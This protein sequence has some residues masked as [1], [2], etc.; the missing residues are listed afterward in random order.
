MTQ[1]HP[2]KIKWDK[3]GEG[4]HRFIVTLPAIYKQDNAYAK[5]RVKFNRTT[6]FPFRITAISE[7]LEP[8]VVDG[9][10]VLDPETGEP[11]VT[12]KAIYVDCGDT[13]STVANRFLTV[14][15]SGE[16]PEAVVDPALATQF[17]AFYFEKSEETTITL[18]AI[19]APTDMRPVSMIVKLTG[20]VSSIS[21][22]PLTGVEFS[23]PVTV[24]E[25]LEQVDF[26]LVSD[27][28]TATFKL[29]SKEYVGSYDLEYEVLGTCDKK[30][31]GTI[32]GIMR[33]A[34]TATDNWGNTRSGVLDL[35][36]D[37]FANAVIVDGTFL[38]HSPEQWATQGAVRVTQTVE[39]D[40][41]F[42]V[43]ANGSLVGSV[44]GPPKFCFCE[45]CC[46]EDGELYI[47]TSEAE[48]DKCSEGNA[49]D[50]L[51]QQSTETLGFT[52]AAYLPP[53]GETSF[54]YSVTVEMLEVETGITVRRD[55]YVVYDPV[56]PNVSLVSRLPSGQT[57]P[58]L[59]V[60]E[61]D[62]PLQRRNNFENGKTAD[63]VTLEI[64]RV[65]TESDPRVNILTSAALQFDDSGRISDERFSLLEVPGVDESG[66]DIVRNFILFLD[67]E[68]PPGENGEYELVVNVNNRAGAN[69][70][71]TL[72]VFTIDEQAP[73]PPEFL[74]D[75]TE[76][77]LKESDDKTYR[78]N[79]PALNLLFTAP[80]NG[81][82]RVT[83]ID[84]STGK[85]T[86][87]NSCDGNIEKTENGHWRVTL[88]PEDTS[89]EDGLRVVMA[90]II[91]DVVESENGSRSVLTGAAVG[92]FDVRVTSPPS[93]FTPKGDT[94]YVTT[95]YFPAFGAEYVGIVDVEGEQILIGE[96][97]ATTSYKQ[98][99]T[100]Q[101]F[102]S[103]IILRPESEED[104]RYVYHLYSGQVT[105]V[106][107]SFG[108]R[109][110]HRAFN[111]T[112]PSGSIRVAVVDPWGNIGEASQPW[113]EN[114]EELYDS[115]ADIWLIPKGG[116]HPAEGS[117]PALSDTEK[118]VWCDNPEEADWRENNV[119]VGGAPADL[120][121]YYDWKIVSGTTVVGT[122]Q[123]ATQKT[124]VMGPVIWPE[125]GNELDNMS[126][127]TAPA[128]LA[129]GESKPAG[130]WYENGPEGAAWP[131]RLNE[132]H[133]EK[134]FESLFFAT[135]PAPA[136]DAPEEPLFLWETRVMIVNQ[137]M[138]K[139][140]KILTLNCDGVRKRSVFL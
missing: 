60:L 113:R 38:F 83:H 35:G 46:T 92:A 4:R 30:R 17:P 138:S 104:A 39:T 5:F 82:A 109:F 62:V 117:G 3:R 11:A 114:T 139:A 79:K 133:F 77:P 106:A 66:A 131:A 110:L 2:A 48:P 87:Y 50:C 73:T 101:N 136:R 12:R 28:I 126:S 95:V 98:A 56:L 118:Q 108:L 42:S 34:K 25:P 26:R 91:G 47:T 19:A 58:K 100:D 13:Y 132:F 99:N 94:K 29:T 75:G 33:V 57:A 49:F 7:K 84:L 8:I 137:R 10:T 80:E 119:F 124:D 89:N 63:T 61:T 125:A 105:D 55:F 135:L 127:L 85:T 1:P 27:G 36:F 65:P 129:E 23:S 70:T 90:E 18:N 112:A 121:D 52:P 40:Q 9:E 59:I 21:V 123:D 24:D 22:D 74:A 86:V 115:E 53:V 32:P 45:V 93:P 14:G 78:T 134:G 67:N 122:E 130:A 54:R 107:Y 44:A 111:L 103:E 76:A 43:I 16:P 68:A 41:I 116:G 120:T 64:K 88:R 102:G 31:T 37:S 97:A 96:E 128:G 140:S 51:L 20:E 71:T 81:P 72:G 15:V 6:E 69:S